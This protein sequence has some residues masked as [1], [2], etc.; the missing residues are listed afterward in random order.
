MHAMPPMP[1]NTLPNKVS[2]NPRNRNNNQIT[3]PTIPELQ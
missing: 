2:N 3:V 1:P